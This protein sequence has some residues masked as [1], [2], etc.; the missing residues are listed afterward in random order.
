[1]ENHVCQDMFRTAGHSKVI[2]DS[3]LCAGYANGQKDACEVRNK[4][5]VWQY[6]PGP[7]AKWNYLIKYVFSY[8]DIKCFF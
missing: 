4:I 2:L 3:F 5:I 6:A 1:M 8:A 7:N